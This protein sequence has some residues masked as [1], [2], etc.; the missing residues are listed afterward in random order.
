MIYAIS[1][2]SLIGPKP[3]HIRFDKIDGFIRTYDGT[4]YLTMFDSGKYDAICNSS[5]Y[6]L[7]YYFLSL[8]SSI[9]HVFLVT[10]MQKS[11][12]SFMILYL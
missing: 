7:M 8:K 10:I 4:R 11:K 12:L 5:R 1:F 9:S 2:K 3:L 6:L